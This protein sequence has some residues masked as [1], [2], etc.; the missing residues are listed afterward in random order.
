MWPLHDTELVPCLTVSSQI[1]VVGENEEWVTV[2]QLPNE[3]DARSLVVP[4]LN[5]YTFYRCPYDTLYLLQV[6]L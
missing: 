3:P 6:P 2:H 5:P 1:G 4:D